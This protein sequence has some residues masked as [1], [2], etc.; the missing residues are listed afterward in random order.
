MYVHVPK[1]NSETPTITS[2][3]PSPSPPYPPP[4]TPPPFVQ[5]ICDRC[6][7]LGWVRL[8]RKARKRG[9]TKWLEVRALCAIW[10]SFL[11]VMSHIW[12][13]HVTRMNE[14]CL[15]HLKR[16][17]FKGTVH[18]MGL[19]SWSHVTHTNKPRHAY[20][21]IK[22]CIWTSRV[23]HIWKVLDSRALC[24]MYCSLRYELCHTWR[25]MSC[26]RMSHVTDIWKALDLR[27]RFK[28][29]VRYMGLLPLSHVT[30]MN[31]SC[32]AYEWVMSRVR[33]SH[34]TYIWK[35]LGLRA[36]CAIW[37]F[38]IT[39]RLKESCP[40]WQWVMSHIWMRRVSHM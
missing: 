38:W 25:F 26:T 33:K 21:R 1:A 31:E 13:R 29:T 28:G 22:S 32:H 12:I 35:S 17:G 23:I 8:Y 9:F 4:S 10:V 2:P 24:T 11:W 16:S 7:I 20:V 37:V 15:I 27:A 39:W 34:V 36:L 3:P 6:L 30:H 40:T 18:Y 5:Y 14:S 19:L